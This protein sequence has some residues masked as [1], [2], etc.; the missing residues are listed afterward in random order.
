MSCL[1]YLLLSLLFSCGEA[2]S[3]QFPAAHYGRAA[4]GAALPDLKITPGDVLDAP[5]RTLCAAGYSATVR[6]VSRSVKLKVFFEYGIDPRDA[7]LY[8]IDHLIS[9]ELGGSNDIAN[10]WPEPYAPTPGA[11]EKDQVENALRRAVCSL[12][13]PLFDAQ[14][15]IRKDWTLVKIP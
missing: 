15:G 12:K 6:N 1:L 14:Q 2:P 9:L 7:A 3:Q 13:M 4:N 11:R 8:E 10:L 5:L